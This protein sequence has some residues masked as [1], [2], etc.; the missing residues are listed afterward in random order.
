MQR[1]EVRSPVMVLVLSLITCGIYQLYWIYKVSEETQSHLGLTTTSPGME[2]LFCIITCGFYT[3]YW[4]YKYSKL[5]A[6]LQQRQGL[7]PDDNSLICILLTIFG[8]GIVSAMIVQSSLNKVWD[9][10]YKI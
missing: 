2:L 4:H 8:F 7:T 1:G 5:V 10:G 6:E 9:A 3:I